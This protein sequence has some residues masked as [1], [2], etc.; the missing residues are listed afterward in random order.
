MLVSVCT[1]K[2]KN[3]HAWIF[4]LA[5]KLRPDLNVTLLSDGADAIHGG[6]LKAYSEPPIRRLNFWMHVYIKNLLKV[7]F[8]CVYLY[9]FMYKLRH[10]IP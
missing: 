10:N 4:Q 7:I 2:D 3:A 5:K 9:V 1:K 6:A 8:V